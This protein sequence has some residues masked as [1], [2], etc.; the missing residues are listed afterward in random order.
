MCAMPAVYTGRPGRCQGKNV[1][2]GGEADHP[3]GALGGRGH[4]GKLGAAG[5]FWRPPY[6]ATLLPEPCHFRRPRCLRGFWLDSL[7]R[8]PSQ[9]GIT[10]SLGPGRP[11][12]HRH[13]EIVSV[14]CIRCLM[15]VEERARLRKLQSG[16]GILRDRA[17]NVLQCSDGTTLRDVFWD[18]F[19]PGLCFWPTTG[20]R[21]A[22]GFGARA[23]CQ[24][25]Q[26]HR[27]AQPEEGGR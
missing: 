24:R 19:I 7:Q 17:V 27:G 3:G 1:C 8:T 14:N 4:H 16:A 11:V 21:G 23:R 18:I 26:G 2:E 20:C 25:S 15:R 13:T 9:V 10:S 22:G 6:S 5:G 12:S